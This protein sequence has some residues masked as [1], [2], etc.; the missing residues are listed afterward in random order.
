MPDF[1]PGLDPSL[2]EEGDVDRVVGDE[3]LLSAG[4]VGTKAG[5]AFGRE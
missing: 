5:D 4:V 2:V 3:T 1:P